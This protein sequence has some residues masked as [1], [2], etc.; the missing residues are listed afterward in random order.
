MCQV[1]IIMGAFNCEK[2]ISEAIES[3]LNQTFMD[4]KLIICDDYSKDNTKKILKEYEEKYSEKILIL[5]N[6]KNYGLNYTLNKCLKYAT[7][8]YV[9]RMDGDDISLPTRLEKEVNILKNNTHISIVSTNMFM[10]DENGIW[11]ETHKKKYPQ[12]ID[13]IKSTPFCHAPCMVRREAYE[14]VNGYSVS[15]KLL[16]VEDY[17]L[18]IKM[19]SKD[20]LGM[21]IQESLY[22]MRDDKN[23]R[24]RRKFKYRI[25]E[26]YVKL[27]AIKMLKLPKI[28]IFLCL[29]PIILGIIPNFMYDILHHKKVGRK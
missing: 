23:A 16:R 20:L 24:N 7:G 21:N 5:E 28:N 27:L 4:W 22:M 17:H 1:S 14:I 6:E 8:D 25:N 15:K 2:T 18:W 3:I 10:F 29:K 12:K 19:Y 11:G 13:L 9:A 26:S